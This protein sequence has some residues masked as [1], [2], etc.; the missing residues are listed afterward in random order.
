VS[1]PSRLALSYNASNGSTPVI[2]ARDYR[3]ER[4]AQARKISHLDRVRKCGRT[5]IGQVMIGLKGGHATQ[6]GLYT[7]GSVWA[8]PVCSAKILTHRSLEIADA[9]KSWES[10]GGSFVFQTLTLSHLRGDSVAKQRSMLTIGW[11]A[12]S[13]GSFAK[14][15][16]RNGQVGYFKVLEPTF[17][18]NGPHLHL[19]LVRFIQGEVSDL[20]LQQWMNKVQTRWSDAIYAA[21][22]RKPRNVA[23]HY[24]HLSSSS[25]L[26]GYFTKNFDN[27][28]YGVDWAIGSDSSNFPIWGLLSKALALPESQ[29][30]Q[31][32]NSY[33]RQSKNMRQITWSRGFRHQL[34]L[35]TEILD[36]EVTR[37]IETFNPKVHILRESVRAFG[38]LGRLHSRVL[39]HIERGQMGLALEILNEHGIKFSL[40][41]N[42]RIED[43]GLP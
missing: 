20:D 18:K 26:Q 1:K 40:S 2:D 17:G 27:P 38:N 22:G 4:R 37:Q 9:L 6:R 3:Y 25:E 29:Y 34:G 43:S 16:S 11:K 41:P 10:K 33:E 32:W 42:T 7:C 39:R 28:A 30:R 24:R 8:C 35:G 13:K 5:P 36:E 23:Q 19:H 15:N 12:I 31:A 21:G 14:T